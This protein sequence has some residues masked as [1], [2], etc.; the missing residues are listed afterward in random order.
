ME[1]HKISW[2]SIVAIFIAGF[3]W[4]FCIE[5]L[6]MCQQVHRPRAKSMCELYRIQTTTARLE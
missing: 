1:I 3:A 4:L 6:C 5:L 2:S